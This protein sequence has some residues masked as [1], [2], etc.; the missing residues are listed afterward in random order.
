MQVDLDSRFWEM[1]LACT[2]LDKS[3]PISHVRA[4]PSIF[5][6]HENCRRWIEA[7]ASTS[8]AG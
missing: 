4:G 8:D 1:Y 2:L 6:E 7:I 3:I 5:V